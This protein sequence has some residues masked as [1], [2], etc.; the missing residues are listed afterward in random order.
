MNARKSVTFLYASNEQFPKEIKKTVPF[1]IALGINSTKKVKYIYTEII[2]CGSKKLKTLIKRK[3][4][5]VHG[6][7][8]LII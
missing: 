5:C 2:Q 3:P 4:F 1:K 6:L 7:K 8:Y